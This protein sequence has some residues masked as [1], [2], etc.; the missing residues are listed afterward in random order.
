MR[1]SLSSVVN[2]KNSIIIECDATEVK[3]ALKAMK[4][5]RRFI[6]KNDKLESSEK[7]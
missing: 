1:I 4:K 2:E 5:F 3:E 7:L 6:L